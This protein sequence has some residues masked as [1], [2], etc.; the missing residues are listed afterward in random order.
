MMCPDC[1]PDPDNTQHDDI[2][3]ATHVDLDVDTGELSEYQAL[4]KSSDGPL[5]ERSCPEEIARLA[6]GFLPGGIPAFKGTNTIRFIKVSD[7]P[8]GRKATFLR[9]CST[10]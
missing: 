2:T 7:I 1:R 9:I 3:H 8:E 4:L 6:Q 10:D 5:R